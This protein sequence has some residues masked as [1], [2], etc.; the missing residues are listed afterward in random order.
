MVIIGNKEME[1][2]TITLRR[3]CTKE[4]VTMPLEN[5]VERMKR[6]MANRVMD[7]FEDVAV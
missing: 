5:F 2:R 6:C 1:E 7:N 4:Q 3:Y